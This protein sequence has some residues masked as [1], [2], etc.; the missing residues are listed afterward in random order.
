[1]HTPAHIRLK[2]L[3][4]LLMLPLLGCSVFAQTPNPDK[5]ALDKLRAENLKALE[6]AAP[7]KAPVTTAPTTPTVPA[8]NSAKSVQAPPSFAPKGATGQPPPVR[9]IAKLAEQF[10]KTP[11]VGQK[12]GGV[13][14]FVSMSMPPAVLK[15]LGRQAAI[16]GATLVLRGFTADP[17]QPTTT[18]GISS[19]TARLARM[20]DVSNTSPAGSVPQWVIDPDAFKN[21]GIKQVPAFV[22]AEQTGE[23]ITCD[24]NKTM[25]DNSWNAAVVYGDMSLADAMQRIS[26]T[27]QPELVKMAKITLSK[28]GSITKRY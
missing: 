9:D 21:F 12:G 11:P 26:R 27:K 6:M 17:N 15:E 25:C 10:Q 5:A 24:A 20:M 2:A 28:F 19:T 4:A 14:V 13:M 18:V 16:G 8:Q 3:A 23:D 22:V 1:M 7:S